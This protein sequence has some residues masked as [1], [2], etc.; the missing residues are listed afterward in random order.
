[1]WKKL[2]E[3]WDIFT[4]EQK[5]SVSILALCG[6][7]AIVL[8]MVHMRENI[9]SPFLVNNDEVLATKKLVGTSLAEDEARLKRID[10]D[11][12]GLSDFDEI[13]IFHTNA[14]LRDTCGDGMS[15]NIRIATGKNLNCSAQMSNP[16]GAIDVS[17]LLRESASSSIGI[18]AI[19]LS[20]PQPIGLDTAGLLKASEDAVTVENSIS[21]KENIFQ[22]L[23]RDPE[24]IRTALQGKVDAE[25]LRTISDAEL[26]KVYDQA[27]VQFKSTA[28]TTTQ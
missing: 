6:F 5:F 17:S 3:R 1:M 14:N 4:N 8:S 2:H 16:S 27:I 10:T 21:D 24:Q 19:D 15:D 28:S 26:L 13:N 20:P 7:F 23:P 18:G 9:R 22:L 25:K 12:D 11:G